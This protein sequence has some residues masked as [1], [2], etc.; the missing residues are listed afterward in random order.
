MKLSQSDFQN[1][2][3]IINVCSIASIDSIIIEDGMLRGINESK[4]CAIISKFQIPKFSQKLGLTRLSALKQ[5]IDIFG[6]SVSIDAK[7]TDRGEISMLE[8][9]SGR[10]KA[11]FRCTSTVMIKAPVNIND[12]QAIK[13]YLNKND[14]KM[15]LDGVRVMSAKKVW[16]IVKSDRTASIEATDV[17]NDCFKMTLDNPAEF[18]NDEV[19][20]TA[21][22]YMSDIILPILR[23][24]TS[25]LDSTVLTIGLKGTLNMSLHGHTITA[26]PQINEDMED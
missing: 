3:S 12:E 2:Q 9:S 13:I 26:L 17:N 8:M 11:Q 10:S 19:D 14:I 1:F 21:Q 15:I 22:G 5:R 4:T 18:L 16:F 25:E 20:S 23:A 6:D 24:I 7:E